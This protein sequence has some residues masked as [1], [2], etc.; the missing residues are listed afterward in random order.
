MTEES[1]R[2]LLIG[3]SKADWLSFDALSAD[4]G[5]LSAAV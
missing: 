5:C 2:T 1:K 3:T 4:L